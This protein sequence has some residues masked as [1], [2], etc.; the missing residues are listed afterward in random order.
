MFCARFPAAYAYLHCTRPE[1][2]DCYAL[3]NKGRIVGRPG[4]VFG[5]EPSYVR[6]SLLGRESD[7]ALTLE[8]LEALVT[9]A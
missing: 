4:V 5:D 3:L 8:R 6:L 7:F 2:G 9:A 1:D